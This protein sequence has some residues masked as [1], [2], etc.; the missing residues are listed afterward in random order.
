MLFGSI[1]KE[2]TSGLSM[3][4]AEDTHVSPPSVVFCRSPLKPAYKMF[5][6]VGSIINDKGKSAGACGAPGG[7]P[8]YGLVDAG[9][10]PRVDEIGIILRHSQRCHDQ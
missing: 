8:V 5:G 10:R 7:S 4:F 2:K 6:S 3:P 9:A 1:A